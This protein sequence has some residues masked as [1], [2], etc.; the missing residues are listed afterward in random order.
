MYGFVSLTEQFWGYKFQHSS[1]SY[2]P[3]SLK[4]EYRMRTNACLCYQDKHFLLLPGETRLSD[5]NINCTFHTYINDPNSRK[6]HL[7]DDLSLVGGDW[8]LQ[9]Y[10]I[11]KKRGNENALD[12]MCAMLHHLQMHSICPADVCFSVTLQLHSASDPSEQQVCVSNNLERPNVTIE[13]LV[14]RINPRRMGLRG[15]HKP[16]GYALYYTGNTDIVVIELPG[17]YSACVYTTS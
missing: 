1:L 7:E 12:G 6:L 8:E 3:V 9:L 14:T 11:S 17:G 15:K 13:D 4:A 10:S 2:R 16:L 5:R